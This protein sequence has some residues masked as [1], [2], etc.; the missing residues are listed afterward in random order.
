MIVLRDLLTPT[1]MFLGCGKVVYLSIHSINRDVLSVVADVEDPLASIKDI[2]SVCTVKV[3]VILLS[4]VNNE[5]AA[6]SLG[7]FGDALDALHGNLALNS[8]VILDI[9]QVFISQDQCAVL[10][11]SPL[12]DFLNDGTYNN[13]LSLFS[14]HL[15]HHLVVLCNL[16]EILEGWGLDIF[17]SIFMI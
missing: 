13:L 5:G 17:H 12:V 3:V 4:D 16:G 15:V 10:S 9:V 14:V 7:A 1:N 11:H 6:S 2:V 8:S